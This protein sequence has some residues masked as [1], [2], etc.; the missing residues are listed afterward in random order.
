MNLANPNALTNPPTETDFPSPL[1]R[2]EGKGEGWV[3]GSW[4]RAPI[5]G[6]SMFP[7]TRNGMRN[8]GY[9]TNG[10]RSF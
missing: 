4:F 7:R 8:Q 2:G 3:L 9:K 6:L 1:L 5:F 10:A